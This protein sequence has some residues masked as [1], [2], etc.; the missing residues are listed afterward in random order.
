MKSVFRSILVS[1]LGFC[2]SLLISWYIPFTAAEPDPTTLNQQ[3]FEQLYKGNPRA[4]LQTWKDAENG[5][6]K[7]RNSQGVTGSKVNQSLAMQALGLY[8][9]ACMILTQTLALESKLCQNNGSESQN[10]KPLIAS[11]AAIPS[12]PAT[13]VGLNSL[14]MC[15]GSLDA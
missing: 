10:L 4:A 14:G 9:Q 7:L 5:Y 3:G 1:L 11:I 12:T 15:C 2:L 8:P 6:R 13:I